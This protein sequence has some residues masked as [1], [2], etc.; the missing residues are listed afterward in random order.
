M[1]RSRSLLA[2]ITLAMAACFTFCWR[3]VEDAAVQISNVYRTVKQRAFDVIEYGL[4]LAAQPEPVVRPAVMLER[5]RAFQVRLAKRERPEI[6]GSWRMCP[7][8]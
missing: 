2:L 6:T 4:Q 1:K 8:T 5:A 7:S 3:T